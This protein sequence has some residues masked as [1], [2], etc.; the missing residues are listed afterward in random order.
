MWIGRF[1]SSS[2]VNAFIEAFCI[3][4][5]VMVICSGVLYLFSFCDLIISFIFF[6]SDDKN[7][8]PSIDIL[9]RFM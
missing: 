9:P 2:N 7:S 8:V 6:A 4:R 3:I 5:F 1:N